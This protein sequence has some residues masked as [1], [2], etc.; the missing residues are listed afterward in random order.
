MDQAILAWALAANSAEMSEV[1]P[2][3]ADTILLC[4]DKTKPYLPR[5][6]TMRV[7][8]IMNSR[9][10]KRAPTIFVRRWKLIRKAFLDDSRA[11]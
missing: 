2:L 10:Q 3:L 1:E 9:F 7:A 6:T 4:G 8:P 5:F 11:Q